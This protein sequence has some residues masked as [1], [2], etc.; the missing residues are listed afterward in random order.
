MVANARTVIFQTFDDHVVALDRA[1]GTLRLGRPPEDA[2]PID[3]DATDD[4]LVGRRC[5]G[6]PRVASKPARRPES[7]SPRWR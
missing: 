1:T 6:A 2:F 3:V 5:A 4:T 7:C